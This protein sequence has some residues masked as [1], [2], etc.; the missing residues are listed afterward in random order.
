M[1]KILKAL[2]KNTARQDDLGQR[3]QQI[4]HV[5]LYPL[6]HESQMP[7]FEQ[8]VNTLV[9]LHSGG[10]GPVVVFSSASQGEGNSFVS[11][12][13]A[14]QLYA[15]MGRPIAWVDGNFVNPQDELRNDKHNFR[16]LLQD[17]KLWAEFPVSDGLTVIA[18]GTRNIKTASLL[19]SQNYDRILQSFRERFYFTII[20]GPAFLDSVD[21]AHLAS[22]ASGL[23]VVVESRGLKHEVIRNGIE[24]LA[25]HGVNVLG[26]VLN[27]RVYDIPQSIYKR[28]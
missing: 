11:Y 22:R 18:N 15:M 23:V 27:R 26:A 24:G 14:R 2:Q 13:V 9:S 17:P 6:P 28:L 16:N 5:G 8:L 20:D 7:E 12:N 10:S 4:D 19:Q 21:V 1:S 3:L 25:G